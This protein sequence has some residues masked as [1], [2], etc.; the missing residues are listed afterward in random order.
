MRGLARVGGSAWAA[1]GLLAGCRGILGITPLAGDR[2]DGATPDAAV[3]D[4]PPVATEAALVEAAMVE[5]EASG[6]TYCQKLS[7]PPKFCADFDEPNFEQGWNNDTDAGIPDPGEI[8][9]GMLTVDKNNYR[10]PPAS[11]QAETPSQFD[12][13]G[14]TAAIVLKAVPATSNLIVQFEVFVSMLDVSPT[15]GIT[16]AG[17]YYQSGTG[18]AVYLD[19]NGL[20]VQVVEA[21][22]DAG[23]LQRVSSFPTGVWTTVELHVN[24]TTGVLDVTTPTGGATSPLPL[25]IENDIDGLDVV[26]GSS[27]T[28]PVGG[29]TADF[30]NVAMYW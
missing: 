27:P 20:E 1:V 12:P 25:L 16:I 6:P 3:A 29:F 26:L 5:R 9:G 24:K 10:S 28:G 21:D 8:G 22:V 11:L 18:V 30:D 13:G 15:G 17:L 14:H 2:P 4:G 23:T 7:P 19:A